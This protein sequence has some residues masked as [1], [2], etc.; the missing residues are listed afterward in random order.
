MVFLCFCFAFLLLLDLHYYIYLSLINGSTQKG[1]EWI[2]NVEAI[3]Q[4][5]H[6]HNRRVVILM[7]SVQFLHVF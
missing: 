4:D 1:G 3:D 5:S 7:G 2:F 6:A